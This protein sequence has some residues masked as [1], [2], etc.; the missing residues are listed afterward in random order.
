M[1][2]GAAIMTDKSAPDDGLKAIKAVQGFDVAKSLLGHAF[3][4]NV[5][6]RRVAVVRNGFQKLH[7]KFL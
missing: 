3:A 5:E 1:R 2:P 4:I 7:E 6:A